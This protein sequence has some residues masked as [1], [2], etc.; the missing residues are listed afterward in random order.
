MPKENNSYEIKNYNE[1]LDEFSL[2]YFIIRKGITLID[3][4]EFKSY[5]R[6]YLK[7]WPLIEKLIK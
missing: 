1:V 5:N 4:E 2:H 3:T 7:N 6:I